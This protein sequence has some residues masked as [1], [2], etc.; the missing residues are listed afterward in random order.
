M[1]PQEP[2][3]SST[4]RTC[5]PATA[6]LASAIFEF[7]LR[8]P[9]TF[10][11][12]VVAEREAGQPRVDGSLAPWRAASTK[13]S[14]ATTKHKGLHSLRRR[15]THSW[16][17]VKYGVRSPSAMDHFGSGTASDR[18]LRSYDTISTRIGKLD[19]CAA[20]PFRPTFG[21]ALREAH[22]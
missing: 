7:W 5:S 19:N 10:R 15:R 6:L 11:R 8:R 2:R 16:N 1:I 14:R 12:S 9:Q 18:G 17:H 13:G 4:S 21:V 20:A 3:S 22:V